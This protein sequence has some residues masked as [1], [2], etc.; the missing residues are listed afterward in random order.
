MKKKMKSVKRAGV[1]LMTVIL[2]AGILAPQNVMAEEEE[3]TSYHFELEKGYTVVAGADNYFIVKDSQGKYGLLDREGHE[4]IEYSYLDMRFSADPDEYDYVIAKQGDNWGILSYDENKLVPFDYETVY[5]YEN[6]NT[7]AAGYNGN[8]THIYNME[9]KQNKHALTGNY[10]VLSDSYYLSDTDIKNEKDKVILNLADKKLSK[11]VKEDDKTKT[12]Y[13]IQ[14]IGQYIAAQ[15]Y[16]DE[17]DEKDDKNVYG[18]LRT[19]TYVKIY[20]GDSQKIAVTP[21]EEWSDSKSETVNGKMELDRVLSDTTFSVK[22]TMG[23]ETF[24]SIYN[25]EEENFSRKF[26]AIG[27]FIDGRAFAEDSDGSVQI[28]NEKGKFLT[29]DEVSISKYKIQKDDISGNA[30][31]YLVFKKGDSKYKLYSLKKG[32]ALDEVYSD[33]IVKDNG[34]VVLKDDNDQYGVMDREGNICIPFGEFKKGDLTGDGTAFYSKNCATIVVDSGGIIVYAYPMGTAEVKKSFFEEHRMQILICIAAG[35]LLII[36]II[37]L[38][39]RRRKKKERQEEEIR[40]AKLREEAEKK[41]HRQEMERQRAE[42]IRQDQLR[43][44]SGQKAGVS[45]AGHMPKNNNTGYIKG[46]R[47]EYQ[48]ARFSIP[49]GMTVRIGRSKDSNNLVINNVKISRNHC[50][51]TYDESRRKYYVTDTSSN[52]VYI[53]GQGRIEK[54]KPVALDVGTE[55]CIGNEENVFQLGRK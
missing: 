23:D 16:C 51:I 3:E 38:I 32:K 17:T 39:T 15:Y 1:I 22:V 9:G 53:V 35:I 52:G 10:Q 8:E 26:K 21:D 54:G 37:L 45:S 4:S 6:D 40:L 25:I 27:S 44:D 13:N 14:K 33:V 11:E 31:S 28:I 29:D 46:L 20:D 18:K 34:Y 43:S 48:G 49:Q 24:Y 5:P 42:R 12:E 55:I 50:T 41:K 19:D 47:G 30:L 36:L 7:A 2:G